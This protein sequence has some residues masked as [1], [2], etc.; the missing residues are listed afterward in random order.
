MAHLRTPSPLLPS[1]DAIELRKK[2]DNLAALDDGDII[3]KNR[4]VILELEEKYILNPGV[5]TI[6]PS[7]QLKVNLSSEE[8]DQ[9][10]MLG[11]Y[12]ALP[13]PEGYESQIPSWLRDFLIKE[14]N[15]FG[16][17]P[18][19]ACG[20]LYDQMMRS[21]EIGAEGTNLSVNSAA[22]LISCGT[23][24]LHD[25]IADLREFCASGDPVCEDTY[26]LEF[27]IIEKVLKRLTGWDSSQK[28]QNRLLAS[29]KT[30]NESKEQSPTKRRKI[31]ESKH[32]EVAAPTEPDL[33]KD[34]ELMLSLGSQGMVM[35]GVLDSS[36]EDLIITPVAHL[37][38]KLEI[39]EKGLRKQQDED[40]KKKNLV[41]DSSSDSGV[42]ACSP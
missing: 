14:L 11:L 7:G 9:G 6:A 29:G 26:A 37:I 17:G 39:V 4:L 42:S 3:A 12:P 20:S 25:S 24:S 38:E 22:L 2:G 13:P 28:L 10:T 34:I 40:R 15:L 16:N 33:P 35:K 18:P 32:V 5:L 1:S 19:S 30:K 27:S 23:M 36:L 31:T 21:R 41:G 8:P